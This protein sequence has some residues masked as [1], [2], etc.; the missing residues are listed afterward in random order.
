MY[1]V[2]Y[3]GNGYVGWEVVNVNF[4]NWGDWVLVLI[5]GYFGCGW[6]VLVCFL[7]I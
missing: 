7:G 4:F 6:V 1:C 5:L 2:F 3:I